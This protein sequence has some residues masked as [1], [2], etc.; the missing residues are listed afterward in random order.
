MRSGLRLARVEG[1]LCDEHGRRFD[2]VRRVWGASDRGSEAE[3]IDA[4][5]DIFSFGAML[6][7]MIS[8]RRA[9]QRGSMIST[10][11]AILRDQPAALRYR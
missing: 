5:A 2:G 11:A 10:L 9:F 7:E 6:Y 8:G 1:C 4:R 3:P